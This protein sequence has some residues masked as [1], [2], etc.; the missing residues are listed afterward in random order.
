MEKKI[1]YY[2]K[3]L[4]EIEAIAK[5][6][7]KPR[8]LLH[9]C[10]APCSTYTLLFLCPIFDVTILFNNS[11][12]YPKSEYDKRLNELF[13][14]IND[15]GKKT[16]FAVKL[17]TPPY[18]NDEFNLALEAYAEL[19]EGSKRCF[20]CYEKRM[21]QAYEFASDNSFEYF[22]TS[23]TISRQKNSQVLNEIGLRLSKE[24]PSTKYFFSDFKK[25]KGIDIAR[26]MRDEYDLYQQQ[27]CGCRYSYLKKHL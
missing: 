20:I 17:V 23:M 7:K 11:N 26:S 10:C 5:D 21:R 13:K 2:L 27:Y 25:N 18:D 1:N 16:G 3:S 6:G 8:L 19:P 15:F 12:I 4:E 9:S 24:F 22:T 14:F